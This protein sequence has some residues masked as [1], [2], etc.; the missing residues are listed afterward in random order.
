LRYQ[1][2]Y[3][4]T[5]S[6]ESYIMSAGGNGR[7]AAE[8]EMSRWTDRQNSQAVGGRMAEH[9]YHHGGAGGAKKS[10]PPRR[11]MRSS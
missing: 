3:A 2:G 11:A 6:A 10:S 7:I 1:K 8:M 9:L 4:G 5:F